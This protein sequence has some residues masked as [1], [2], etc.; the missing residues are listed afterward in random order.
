MECALQCPFG[1]VYAV[2]RDPDALK[3][4]EENIRQFHLQNVDVVAGSAPKALENLPAPTHVFLGGTGGHAAEILALL[5]KLDTPVRL[6]G[7]AVTLESIRVF[8]DLLQKKKNFSA[9]QIAVSR[10]E[11]MGGYH[12]L[13]A[14]NPVFVF[15]ADLCGE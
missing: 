10:A 5:E 1:R 7:T 9:V 12:M 11:L 6:C 8:F 2:E 14:Q 15:S 3:L 4:I 13:R